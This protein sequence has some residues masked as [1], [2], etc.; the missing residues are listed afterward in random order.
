MGRRVTTVE[1]LQFSG[2]NDLADV[3]RTCMRRRKTD[4]GISTIRDGRT[5]PIDV[6]VLAGM[7]STHYV[8]ARCLSVR[9]SV[10]LSVC[11]FTPRYCVA[12]AKHIIK[13]FHRRV[14]K[15]FYTVSTKNKAK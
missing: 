1:L 9:P 15:P 7:H 2:F 11:V 10:R 6:G 4:V 3:C 5:C 8:V 12:T 14:T 13:L